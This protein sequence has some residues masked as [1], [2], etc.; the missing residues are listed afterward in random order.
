MLHENNVHGTCCRNV[1]GAFVAELREVDA[2]KEGLSGARIRLLGSVFR[3]AVSYGEASP[4]TK[5]PDA[6]KARM[7]GGYHVEAR[8]FVGESVVRLRC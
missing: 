1:F 5:P 3:S 8:L 2:G 6:Q 4:D 7:P